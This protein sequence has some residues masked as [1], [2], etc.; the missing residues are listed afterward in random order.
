VPIYRIPKLDRKP[1]EQAL[2]RGVRERNHGEMALGIDE[3]RVSVHAAPLPSPSGLRRA[4]RRRIDEHRAAE[5]ESPAWT[6]ALRVAGQIRVLVAHH[7]RRTLVGQNVAATAP[8]RLEETQEIARGT[9][10]P[11]A[12]G[13][14][15]RRIERARGREDDARTRHERQRHDLAV[16]HAFRPGVASAYGTASRFTSAMVNEVS[17]ISRGRVIRSATIST[18]VPTIRVSLNARVITASISVRKIS[19]SIMGLLQQGQ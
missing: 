3:P 1:A 17:R 14:E 6:R 8:D 15:R 13:R 10:H 4:R 16:R 18:T 19:S 9:D 7:L 12:T 11:S 2:E 5:A